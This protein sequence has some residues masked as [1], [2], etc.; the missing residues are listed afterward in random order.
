MDRYFHSSLPDEIRAPLPPSICDGLCNHF[1]AVHFE[2]IGSCVIPLQQLQ[3]NHVKSNASQCLLTFGHARSGFG[4]RRAVEDHLRI[5]DFYYKKNRFWGGLVHKY[6]VWNAM[7]FLRLQP[8][9][10]ALPP[11]RPPPT[12]SL[13][14]LASRSFCNDTAHST[15]MGF[16]GIHSDYLYIPTICSV[17]SA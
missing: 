3:K 10:L 14:P 2:G 15:I 6:L 5:G 9:L 7:F 8:A 13:P 1:W 17:L 12:R 11:L 16:S 4:G